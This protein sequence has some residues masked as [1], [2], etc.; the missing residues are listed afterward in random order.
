MYLYL[1][2]SLRQDAVH[3]LVH[4]AVHYVREIRGGDLA[5]PNKG[6]YASAAEELLC[7][8]LEYLI[9]E[10]AVRLARFETSREIARVRSRS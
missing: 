5:E 3:E 4:A 10:F 6:E 9:S 7:R 8:S 2:P 1:N